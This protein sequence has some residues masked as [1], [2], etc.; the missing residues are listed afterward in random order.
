MTEDI[1][2]KELLESIGSIKKIRLYELKS[3]HGYWQRYNCICR[4][5]TERL[6]L[7]GESSNEGKR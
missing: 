7:K 3:D 1:D 2:I 6:R 4:N 5:C